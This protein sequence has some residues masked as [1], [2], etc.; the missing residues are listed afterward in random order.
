[1]E[2]FAH[3][4]FQEEIEQYR[5]EQEPLT[6]TNC[7]LKVVSY[8]VVEEESTAWGVTQRLDGL[9]ESLLDAE[10][11]EDLPQAFVPHPVERLKSKAA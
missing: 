9:D 10:L 5:R 11:S 7:G 2:G 1:M 8:L 3:D 6:D 4:L